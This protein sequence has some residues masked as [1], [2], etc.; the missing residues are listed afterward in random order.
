MKVRKAVIAAA[1]QGIRFLPI[2]RSVPKEMLPLVDRPLVHYAVEEALESGIE[3]IILI[4]ALGKHAMEDYFDRSLELEFFLEKKGEARRLQ[5]MRELGAL[6]DICYLRQ[7]EQL[8]L[9]H[10][11]L[12]ARHAVADAPFAVLL[13]D[14]IIDSPE[15]ALKKMM[16]VYEQYGGS[17]VAVERIGREDT[18]K[19]GVIRPEKVAEGV[20]RVLELVEKPGPEEA[21]SDLGV[22]GRYILSPGIFPALLST[23]PGKGGEIQLTDGLQRLLREEPVYAC[24][25]EGERYDTGD[26]LGWLKAN[27]AF[28]LKREDMA[29]ELRKYLETLP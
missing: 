25:L 24:E 29:P 4:T 9:G 20:Y 18:R 23:P 26:P 11:V 28:A 17:V 6:V 12:T 8:G 2:T 19:Y 3:Q 13:P 21:P 14:D 16:A 15:P 7:K 22:V 10:A 5:S 1:G 27:L